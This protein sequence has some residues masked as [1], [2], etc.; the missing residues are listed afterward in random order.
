MKVSQEE[1]LEA[2]TKYRETGDKRRL[3]Q[4]LMCELFP[5][6]ACSEVFHEHD[7]EKAVKE[8]GDRYVE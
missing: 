3:G 6:E 8:F 5:N 4:F 2:M 1:M 7:Q